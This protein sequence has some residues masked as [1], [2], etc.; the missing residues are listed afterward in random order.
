[1]ATE[2]KRIEESAMYSAQC[3][4]GETKRWR[5]VHLSLGIP[6]DP[7]CQMAAAVVS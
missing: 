1:M 4:F 2:F 5:A 6:S 7:V 3:Q